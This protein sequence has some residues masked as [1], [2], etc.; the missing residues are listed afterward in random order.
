MSDDLIER[1]RAAGDPRN[2]KLGPSRELYRIAADALAAKEAALSEMR[3]E[4]ETV[5]GYREYENR[6]WREAHGAMVQRAQ[7]LSTE[8][9][10]AR[11]ALDLADRLIERGYGIDTPK[12][13]HVAYRSA[14]AL[15]SQD[16]GEER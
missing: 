3:A 11:K 14:R 13:W 10:R 4:L 7:C 5:K 2:Q 16:D 9:E 1:L 8:L 15:A 6:T 12:E